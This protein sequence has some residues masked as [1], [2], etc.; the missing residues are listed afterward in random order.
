MEN[1]VAYK[2][3][4]IQEM[5]GVGYGTACK[6]IRQVK[7]VSDSLKVKGL[8]LKEDWE[9]YLALKGVSGNGLN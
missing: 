7:S 3:K 1:K 5:L 8:I 6:I 9:K 2:V 4:D